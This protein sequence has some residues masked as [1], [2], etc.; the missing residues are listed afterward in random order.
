MDGWMGGCVDKREKERGRKG[1][2]LVGLR[3]RE[4][5]LNLLK[6]LIFIYKAL[7]K[8]VKTDESKNIA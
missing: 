7:I 6:I 1:A 4:K 2:E 3:S 8:L 5:I